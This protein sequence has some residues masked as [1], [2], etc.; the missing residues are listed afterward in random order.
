[1]NVYIS[2]NAELFYKAYEDLWVAERTWFA[3]PNIAMWHCTQSV[4][5][6]MKGFLRCHNME[7]DHVHELRYLLEDVESV[8]TV[9]GECKEYIIYLDTFGNKLRY[10][11]MPNDPSPE[12]VQ[13]AISRTKHIIQYFKTYP[14]ISQ[15]LSEAYE[16][17]IKILKASYEKYSVE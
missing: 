7:Y 8:K 16:V 15:Y 10:R 5:K 2:R 13:L 9:S 1:M 14:V 6:I 17:H 11:N 4:E 3:S 12:D